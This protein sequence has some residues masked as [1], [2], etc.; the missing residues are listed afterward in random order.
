MTHTISEITSLKEIEIKLKKS[1]EKFQKLIDNTHDIIYTLNIDGCFTFVSQSWTELLGHNYKEIL[2]QPFK[3]YVH[4]EDIS[5][6]YDFLQKVIKTK[7][8][9]SGVE[10]R[11][12][13]QDGSWKWHMSNATP[14]LD[15]EGNV[16]GINGIARDITT[17]KEYEKELIKNK[18]SAE[19][20]NNMKSL[21]LAN[22]SHELRTPMNGVLGILEILKNT[23]L[24]SQQKEYVELISSSGRSLVNILND[25]LD[26]SKIQSNKITFQ[27][28]P[29]NLE[30]CINQ[31][32]SIMLPTV[33]SK[34]LEITKKY[35]SNLPTSIIGD[36]V[37]LS[38][39]L[40]NILANAIKFTEHGSIEINVDTNMINEENIECLFIIKDTGIGIPKEKLD[41]I[42]DKFAQVDE[43]LCRKYG[44]VG[45][46]LNITKELIYKLGGTIKLHSE[47][48]K[49]TTFNITIP[50]KINNTTNTITKDKVVYKNNKGKNILI[51]EDDP[52]SLIVAKY[53]LNK[54]GYEC[55]SAI[56][57]DEA[58]N[59][60]Q[61]RKFDAILMDVQLPG[62]CS[63]FELTKKIR[64]LEKTNKTHTPII[65]CSANAMIENKEE[66]IKCGAEDY[67]TKPL[68]PEKLY[69]TLDNYL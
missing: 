11:V 28:V 37:R 41:Y 7:S 63:G 34:G 66:G 47:L 16:I 24:T 13:H 40:T 65:I 64:E 50:Y 21:F 19:Y 5:K 69:Q 42:F 67:V 39:I 22:I 36:K 44:G 48:Y 52:T 6:C 55:S 35:T 9:Q 20:A 30:K 54:K 29:F 3:P 8:R 14:L 15:D 4:D 62:N 46:G 31:I 27:N 10:Y 51:I 12:K 61:K 26:L 60:Y 49:G 1:K 23:E 32:Y 18:K 53:L 38:Q 2:G 57:C 59:L 58:I 56:N 43:S 68:I 45:L 17:Y 33:K 25:I